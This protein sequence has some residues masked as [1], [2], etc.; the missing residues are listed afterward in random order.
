ML[1]MKLNTSTT[2]ASR[3]VLMFLQTESHH[4]PFS[5]TQQIANQIRNKELMAMCIIRF[6]AAQCNPSMVELAR[7]CKRALAADLSPEFEV[8]FMGLEEKCNTHLTE[9]RARHHLHTLGD[10]ARTLHTL[11][12]PGSDNCPNCGLA[13][14]ANPETIP[15]FCEACGANPGTV[16]ENAGGVFCDRST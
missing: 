7:R 1:L 15:I 14:F 12:A 4:R 13:T 5:R 9:W 2:K 16:F 8:V 6:E 11:L 10:W 3:G